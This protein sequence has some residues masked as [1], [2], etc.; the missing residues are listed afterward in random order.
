MIDINLCLALFFKFLAH[1]A[2]CTYLH[3]TRITNGINSEDKNH[4]EVMKYEL[5]VMIRNFNLH[6]YYNLLAPIHFVGGIQV[7]FPN[8]FSKQ[9]QFR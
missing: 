8:Y 4:L 6:G 3:T 2:K 7:T 1:C 5:D 9:D